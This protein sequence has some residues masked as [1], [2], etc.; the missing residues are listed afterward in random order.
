[1]I[2]QASA[3]AVN[4]SPAPCIVIKHQT[5]LSSIS[6]CF[7]DDSRT[8]VVGSLMTK[9]GKRRKPPPCPILCIQ[10]SPNQGRRHETLPDRFF[11]GDI[12]TG[13]ENSSISLKI[14][15]SPGAGN[16]FRHLTLLRLATKVHQTVPHYSIWTEYI[17]ANATRPA[18]ADI[19]KTYCG[20]TASLSRSLCSG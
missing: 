3:L 1:L 17:A 15:A 12:T 16:D 19:L 7:D 8:S 20:K 10:A 14:I 9:T 5:S 2:N 11:L 4:S 6:N 13:N 18:V